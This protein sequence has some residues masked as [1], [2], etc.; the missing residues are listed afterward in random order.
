MAI[1]SAVLYG[2]IGVDDDAL[3]SWKHTVYRTT[4]VSRSFKVLRW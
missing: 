1:G 4:A 3:N 2:L